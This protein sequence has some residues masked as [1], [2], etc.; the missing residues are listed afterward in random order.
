M[1]ANG[2]D[3]QG[4]L[5]DQVY[6]RQR[7]F[8]DFTRKYYLLGRDRL[9]RDLAL[10]EGDRLVEVGCGTARNLIAAA[11][12]Y[13]AA[14]FFGVDASQAML[15]TARAAIARAGLGERISVRYGYAEEL[16]PSLLGESKPFEHAMFSYS[17]SMIP[18]WKGAMRAAAGS[19]A[20]EGRLHVVDFG[21]LGGLGRLGAGALRLWLRQFHVQ[22][23]A[24]LLQNLEKTGCDPEQTLR[25]SWGRYS[26]R[27]SG[28]RGPFLSHR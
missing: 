27:W 24:E 12:R 4:A 14:R 1:A 13:P 5:M 26:F 2:S 6:R 16:T 8:Y 20:A 19:L 17:L 3:R 21:D 9:I 10:G 28:P 7:H 11:R 23:R 25:I 22:P 18:D 15:E